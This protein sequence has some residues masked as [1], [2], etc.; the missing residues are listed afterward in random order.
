[1]ALYEITFLT[2]E[3]TDPGV[4]NLL[5]Q[6][7]GAIT[8]ESRLGRRRLAYPIN[9]ET[10]AA[11]TTYG[12]DILS[13]KLTEIDQ[14]LRLNNDI[15]RYL[16][17][18]KPLLKADKQVTKTVREAIKAAEKLEDTLPEAKAETAPTEESSVSVEEAIEAALSRE[19]ETAAPVEIDGKPAKRRVAKKTEKTPAQPAAE[20]VAGATVR[21]AA[22]ADAASATEEDRLKA[23][24]DKL[25]EILGE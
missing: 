20:D 7:G 13:A 1:M 18:A 23:L 4:R 22:G 5:E 16:I 15:L 24:E 3:E 17:V 2:K 25:G 12:F 19:A 10:Q 14:K 11:Y 9:K 8:D 6:V 21:E